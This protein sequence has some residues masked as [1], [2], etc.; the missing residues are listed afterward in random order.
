MGFC[1]FQIEYLQKVYRIHTKYRAFKLEYE[2][3]KSRTQVIV[4]YLQ[5]SSS[6]LS[7]FLELCQ[8]LYQLFEVRS[9]HYHSVSSHILIQVKLLHLQYMCQTQRWNQICFIGL[10][11]R[12]QMAKKNTLYFLPLIIS[13]SSGIITFYG[14]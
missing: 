9:L 3:L 6:P 14:S 5:Q 12:L 1:S 2:Y 10:Y 7:A 13:N 8:F 4:Q 11:S